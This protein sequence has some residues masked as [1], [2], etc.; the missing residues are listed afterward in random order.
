[1]AAAAAKTTPVKTIPTAFQ[2]E[3]LAQ[4]QACTGNIPEDGVLISATT[5]EAGEATSTVLK[6]LTLSAVR[7]RVYTDDEGEQTPGDPGDAHA[8]RSWQTLALS[9]KGQ[10]LRQTVALAG[11][12]YTFTFSRCQPAADA[13]Q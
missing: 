6:V 9:N 5:L 3:W 1:M 4:P 2:G 8:G 7:I 13:G 11:K 10:T 12:P